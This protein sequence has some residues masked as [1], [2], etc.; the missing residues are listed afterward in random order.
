MLIESILLSGFRCFGPEPLSVTFADQ[1]TAVVGPNA[2]GKTALLQALAKVF[3][4]SR[5]QRTIHRSDFHLA[6]GAD[7][8]SRDPRELF[9]DVLVSLPELVDGTATPET[10]A[11][12]FRHM[13]IER[14]G[15]E[16]V[17]RLRLEAR[18][19]DDG[20]A[21][22]EVS[23]ELFWVDTLTP[24]PT[25]AQKHPIS[26]ADRGLV[27]LYYTPASRDAA[28]QI[29][30]TTGALAARLLR[31][32]EW[33]SETQEALTA[34]SENLSEAFDAET[35]IAAISKALESRW[36]DLHD[37][38]VDTKP[39]LSLVSRRFEEVISRI[40]IIFEQAP[41]G[42]ERGLEA[43]SD[44][45][46]S[47]FYFA[48]AAAVF[49]LERQ[50]VAGEVE[51]FRDDQL[52]IPAL[53]IFALE[54]PENHLSP[55]FLARII[56][57]VKSL[58]NEGGA[59]AIITSH[60][61]A[62][63]SRV[64]PRE[65]RY[66]RCDP[67]TRCS[68]VKSIKMPI[69]DAEATKFVR[70]A[71]L[72]YPELYFARF[73]LLVEGDSERIVLPRLAEALD[74]LIDP[75]FVAIVPLGGRHVQ[76]FWRL[77]SDLAI[78]YATLPDL[79][80]GREGGGF[81]RV[82]TAIENLIEIGVSKTKL[83]KIEG[84][85]LSDE[86]FQKMHTWQDVED[87]KILTGWV[88]SLKPYNVFFS[89][90]LDL[91]LSMLAAFPEAYKATVPKGGGPKM[92]AEK[93]AEVVFGTAG[94]GLTVYNGAIKFYPELLPAYR[95]HFLTNRKPATHLAALT[96]L[97]R[98]ELRNGMPDVLAGVLK[99]VEAHVRRD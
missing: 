73:V 50:V 28:A 57:Q 85:I 31:A 27:Q 6:P 16:P 78:P 43:L 99:H 80:L 45:Q 87:R 74:L 30:A 48:L 10:I 71:I 26:P 17:C 70:G 20:T 66:C 18:W 62:V 90:P 53:T 96:Q 68:S 76:H 42:Q 13:R 75:A 19:E 97:K 4:V 72:A 82:K 33:S 9:I 77:L 61:P 12:S 38:V 91:D 81:G 46:Q 86:D 44:G 3:G 34:A 52:S 63:L 92:T 29:R 22:G 69:D 59:Q 60:S 24:T 88:G 89:A 49:D 37:E 79:D 11:P 15:E 95:Y 56:R 32:I 83:L 7:R 21:E 40:A 5:A 39:R 55:Y 84:G 93:A 14:T 47:L 65:V 64:K 23:Q 25:D 67:K 8:D 98:K 35:A 41:D 94:P 54:E 1:V 58:T 2:A 51:G 36:S